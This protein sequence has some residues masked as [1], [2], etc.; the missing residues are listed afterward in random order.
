MRIVNFAVASMLA[1]SALAQYE[2]DYSY[3]Y[4]FYDNGEYCCIQNYISRS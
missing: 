1:I 3:G 2:Y 4:D